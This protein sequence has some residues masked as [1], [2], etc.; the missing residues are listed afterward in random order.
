MSNNE[1]GKDNLKNQFLKLD[2]GIGQKEF[3]VNGLWQIILT[4]LAYFPCFLG[5]I[6]INKGMIYSDKIAVTLG[7][8]ITLGA[9]A[10]IWF[11]G[12]IYMSFTKRRLNDIGYTDLSISQVRLVTFFP[13]VNAI[14]WIFLSVIK[15]VKNEKI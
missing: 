5:I 15:G 12:R 13:I 3:F 1:V 4:Y 14:A 2:G 6:A 10:V 7:G 8:A 9:I 11:I